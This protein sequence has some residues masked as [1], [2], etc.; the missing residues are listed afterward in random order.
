WRDYGYTLFMYCQ[1]PAQIRP[2]GW[3]HWE[4]Q[5]EQTA[6]YLE[7]ENTGEGANSAQRASWSRQLTKEEAK[8]IT[9][10]NGVIEREY[11][12]TDDTSGL[13]F[14]SR[15]GTITSTG[16][17]VIKSRICIR[18]TSNATFD[19]QNGVL[20]LEA[21]IN[22]CKEAVDEG[23][24]SAGFT[25]I[26]AGTLKLTAAGTSSGDANINEGTLHLTSTGVIVSNVNV[27]SGA[28]FIDAAPEITSAVTLNGGAFTLGDSASAATITIGDFAVTDG[29]INF[30]F[31]S[32]DYDILTTS[33]AMLTS[34]TINVMFNN[35]NETTWWDNAP[36]TGYALINASSMTAY[37]NSFQLLV[38]SS[39]TEQWYLDTAGNQFV[40]KKQGSEPP[41]PTVDYYL[42]NTSE[43]IEA[44]SWTIDGTNKKGAK[45]IAGDQ[46]TAT[47]D[48][49]VDMQASGTYEVAANKE[50]TLTGV[51]SGSGNVTKLGD[52]TLTLSGDN[53]YTG[54]TTVSA[55][56]LKL[57]KVGQK[58]TLATGSTLTVDGVKSVVTGHGDIFGYTDGTVA[59]I[60]L[61]NGGTLHNDSTDSHITVGAEIN[62]NSG[63]ISSEDGAGSS[64]YGNYVFDNAINVLGGTNN[65]ITANRIA[66]R[67][68][69]AAGA[70]KIN[71][72]K[73]AILT[74]S[75]QII[76]PDGYPV[77]LVKEG[78]GT[79]VLSGDNTFTSDTTV[80]AGTL[81]LTKVGQ[82]G[83]L[84]TG[85]TLTVD[86]A[87]SVVTGHGDI[88][89]YTSGTVAT[90]NLTNGGTLHNDSTGNH[91]TVGAEINM[92]HGVI[93]SENGNG[94]AT[95]GNYV[96]DSAINVLG[97]TDNAITANRI[98]LRN[99]GDAGAGKI[100]V[101][102]NA[103][104]TI[105]SQ[106]FD[107]DGN[108]IPLVK[109]G[110]GTLVL[111][112]DN[113]YTKGT[114]VNEGVLQLTGAAVKANSPI[115]IADNA[116]L[117]YN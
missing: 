68:L 87:N 11:D 27:A 24:P 104:L 23:R 80:S 10:E 50:L 82:K 72:A 33:S 4:K 97:G 12:Y 114:N 98:T 106:I 5:R 14:Q 83:T 111:S 47:Y 6:R 70:G 8:D 109:Q 28:T 61:T 59:T 54:D 71:V 90:V 113:T 65:A 42:A 84:A 29:T 41:T 39:A 115:A 49:P 75:S 67:N 57:T 22:N 48:G 46:S 38:N 101:D 36:D 58:G 34:G 96:F 69:G 3:H 107:P 99:L 44:P 92:N 25:K 100:T 85:S 79:L 18:S 40:L 19:V 93:S 110:A 94:S 64:T 51:I 7:F 52:G 43:A 60:N 102:E 55:G 16:D 116:T 32:S 95:Y 117:E 21:G 77:P 20:T 103:K 62:M 88:L 66:L 53:T 76:N 45:F 26:G 74:I 108:F 35:G 37:P 81:N 1:L 2:E 78:E 56:T 86:G 15:T 9:L 91:I 17:S 63:V 73:D 105:S 30:D 112:G 31:Y 89:G 13:D